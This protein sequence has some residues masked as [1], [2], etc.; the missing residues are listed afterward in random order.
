LENGRRGHHRWQKFYA[1]GHAFQRA[2]THCPQGHE[3]T[4]EN[5]ALH[6]KRGYKYRRCMQCDRDRAN[7]RNRRLAHA[8]VPN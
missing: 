4:S 7:A 5:T 2:K 8:R 1:G 6:A 3:Y